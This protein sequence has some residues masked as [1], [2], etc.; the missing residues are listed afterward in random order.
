MNPRF[1]CRQKN[2][3]HLACQVH[4]ITITSLPADSKSG[5]FERHDLLFRGPTSTLAGRQIINRS[6][7]SDAIQPSIMSGFMEEAAS[8]VLWKGPFG[9]M[10]YKQRAPSHG[11]GD[12]QQ[13]PA[14]AED[15]S[16]LEER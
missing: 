11:G 13:R 12:L 16:T 7:Q 10:I 6:C 8:N 15:G 4:Q 14:D 3:S 1:A 5:R 9:S 2:H